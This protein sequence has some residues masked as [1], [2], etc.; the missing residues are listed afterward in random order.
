[1]IEI[2]VIK[3]MVEIRAEYRVIKIR[4]AIGAINESRCNINGR[5]INR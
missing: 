4:T 2:R 5:H 3:R 1:M